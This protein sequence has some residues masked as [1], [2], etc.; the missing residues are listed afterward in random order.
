MIL[1]NLR[2]PI[3]LAPMAGGPSTP[4][5]AAA[6]CGAG[7]LGFLA[8]GYLTPADTAARLAALRELTEVPFGVNLFVPGAP[9]PPE[10]FA[11]YLDRLARH[12]ALG[13]ARFDDDAWNEKLDLLT[14]D[15]VAVVSCTFGC[16]SDAE[17][18]RLHRAGSECG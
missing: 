4:E 11:P 9:T 14:A 2:T 5:L 16:P 10:H 18:E 7:G 12:F 13:E 8:A 1:D 17:I 15:P 3:V 6:V